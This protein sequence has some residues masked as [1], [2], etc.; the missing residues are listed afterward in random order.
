VLDAA[1]IVGDVSS[2]SMVFSSASEAILG[3]ETIQR[4]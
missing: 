1:G 4:R 3:T 2:A